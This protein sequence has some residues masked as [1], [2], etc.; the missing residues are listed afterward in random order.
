VQQQMRQAGDP[1]AFAEMAFDGETSYARR[2]AGGDF[3][4]E[5]ST[6][7]FREGAAAPVCG[8]F[9]TT[10]IHDVLRQVIG[11]GPTRI[12]RQWRIDTLIPHAAIGPAT[13]PDK[14][15][16]AWLKREGKILLRG[17]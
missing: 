6:N 7:P 15:G 9:V 14:A 2:Q 13:E 12:V 4:V 3:K 11:E 17:L 16:A 1:Y 10:S 8:D 5:L